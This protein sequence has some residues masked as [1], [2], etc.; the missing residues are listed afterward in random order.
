MLIYKLHVIKPTL[1]YVVFVY[2]SVYLSVFSN[3][4]S[5]RRK[6]M[7]LNSKNVK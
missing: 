4:N 1:V 5:V 7:K 6:N 2:N 3:F